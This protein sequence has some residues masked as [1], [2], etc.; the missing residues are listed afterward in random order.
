MSVGSREVLS[1]VS[2][3]VS[4]TPM[5][6]STQRSMIIDLGLIE[7]DLDAAQLRPVEVESEPAMQFPIEISRRLGL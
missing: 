4:M 6:I 5:G 1:T 7:I 3:V 2:T